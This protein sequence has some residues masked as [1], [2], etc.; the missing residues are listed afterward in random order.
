MS[1]SGLR[2]A[3]TPSVIA[4]RPDDPAPTGTQHITTPSPT[5][6]PQPRPPFLGFRA[7][8]VHPTRRQAQIHHRN[9]P[10]VTSETLQSVL[11]RAQP[12]GLP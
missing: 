8:P 1:P 7:S 9:L 11:A 5:A 2:T 4:A 6:K 12:S 10:A 3:D